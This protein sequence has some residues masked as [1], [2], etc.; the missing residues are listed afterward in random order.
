MSKSFHINTN[1]SAVLD[2]SFSLEEYTATESDEQMIISVC[3]DKRTSGYSTVRLMAGTLT[4]DNDNQFNEGLPI[5]AADPDSLS[6][7]AS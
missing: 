3:K 4:V 5:P 6:T 2:I 1:L 7:A